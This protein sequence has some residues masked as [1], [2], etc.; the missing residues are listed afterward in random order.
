MAGDLDQPTA[1]IALTVTVRCRGVPQLRSQRA[2][3]VLAEVLITAQLAH[4]LQLAGL[5]TDLGKEGR[6]TLWRIDLAVSHGRVQGG[7]K[8]A[9]LAAGVGHDALE[10]LLGNGHSVSQTKKYR[11][12][13]AG[14]EAGTATY[15]SR[16][17]TS[18]GVFFFLPAALALP[19]F[20]ALH[21][22]V[23]LHPD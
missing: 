4:I 10:L 2:G 6:L 11:S 21:S 3:V 17:L 7:Y 1:A 8:N 22:T 13:A 19:F 16:T 14:G 20:P 15:S 9:R 12:M 5:M 23:V 18:L